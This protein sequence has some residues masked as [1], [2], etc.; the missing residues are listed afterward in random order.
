MGFWW[1]TESVCPASLLLFPSTYGYSSVSSIVYFLK[2]Q[3]EW[4]LTKTAL[5]NSVPFLSLSLCR[6]NYIVF[7][8]RSA[9]SPSL[10]LKH[11]ALF[12]FSSVRYDL[13][14]WMSKQYK[15]SWSCSLSLSK[16]SVQC[17]E[18]WSD[19]CYTQKDH[20]F[21]LWHHIDLSF[22]LAVTIKQ[23]HSPKIGKH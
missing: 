14:V 11:V 21:P 8:S 1:Q 10:V 4:I 15:Q 22:L 6:H 7:D 9:T 17:G 16:R 23:L 20:L 13:L 2:L 3:Q 19:E 18:Y 12:G 5:V